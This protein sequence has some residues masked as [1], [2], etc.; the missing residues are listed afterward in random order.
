MSSWFFIVFEERCFLKTKLLKNLKKFQSL[1]RVKRGG[2]TRV[3]KKKISA[4]LGMSRIKISARLG[5]A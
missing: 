5:M 4:R 1:N 3:E 2:G